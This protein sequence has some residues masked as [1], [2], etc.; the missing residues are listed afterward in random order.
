MKTAISIVL[1]FLL[2]VPAQAVIFNHLALFNV[3]L[4]IVFIYIVIMLPVT[5]GTNWSTTIG[6]LAGLAVDIFC[7]TAGVNTLRMYRAC[8]LPETGIP[9][10]CVDR[11]R[12]C[13]PQS[14]DP[15]HGPWSLHEVPCHNGAD[16]LHYGVYHRGIPVFQFPTAGASYHSIYN[17]L[18][19]PPLR[20]RLCRIARP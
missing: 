8:F 14:L 1:A 2:L 6:F 13:R 12:S 20:S 16:I 5:L 3:A 18:F 10:L 9:P 15:Q 7:D 19:Y 11:R 4:P 17:L